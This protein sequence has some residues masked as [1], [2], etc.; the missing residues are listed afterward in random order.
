M[1][2]RDMI[3][4]NY[5]CPCEPD[6]SQNHIT[7]EAGL[8]LMILN[9]RL[10]VF[11]VQPSGSEVKAKPMESEPFEQTHQPARQLTVPPRRYLLAIF[12]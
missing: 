11:A 4:T 7:V 6:L 9:D 1:V 5:Q 12:D 8:L 10:A 3:R 2:R